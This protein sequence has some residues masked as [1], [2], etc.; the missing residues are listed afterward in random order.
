[1]TAT[2]TAVAGAATGRPRK[3]MRGRLVYRARAMRREPTALVGGG[4]ALLL[5]YLVIAP[6]V[7]ML[8]DA[9]V[10]GAADAS[11]V[12]Q[13]S[14]QLTTYYLSR[15][16]SSPISSLLFWEPLQ[17]T[18]VTALG[19]TLLALSLGASLAWL[20]VRTDMPGRRW[21]AG[22]LVVPYM[23]PSWTFALA[24]I[25]IFKNRT[26]A[27]QSG[28][29]ESMGFAPPDWLAYGAV[30]II[31]TLGLHYFPFAFLLFGNALRRFDAQLE[32][33]ARVLGA[34][35]RQ[36]LWRIVLP[37]ML[38]AIL[39]SV[40][41][42]FSRVL[43]TFGTPYVLGLP[44]RYSVLSTS[45]Y[46]NFRSGSI[47]VMAVIAAVILI[48]GITVIAADAW[49]LRQQRKFITVGARTSIDRASRLRGL[50]PVAL[51]AAI[52][53]FLATVVIPLGAL[54]LSTFMRVPGVLRLDNLTTD[55]WIG[56]I[57]AFVGFP[58]GILR[59]P[60]L[61]AALW[62]SVWIVGAAAIC[63]G[64]LGLLVGY[65]VVRGQGSLVSQFLRQV[66]F[67]PYLVPGIA[68]AAAYLSLF[69]VP[70]GPVPALYG[71]MW[72]LLLVLVVAYLPY[73]SRSGIAA[74]LQLGR[75]P[76]EAAQMSGARW[77]RR[78]SRIVVPIQRAALTT[79]IILPFISGLKELSLVVMLATPGTDVLSTLSVRLV[80][81]GYQQLAN[82]AVL[83]IAVVAFTATFLAQRL[84]G[85]SLASGLG[86]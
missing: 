66:S 55:F 86:R 36:T 34:K 29:L 67:L 33:S 12:G 42:I 20:V 74:M 45:L 71:T 8:S 40:L 41:L 15:T 28:F 27:G 32:E 43:G 3:S 58:V 75:E 76:E 79:G 18:V 73:A 61:Y 70:R 50:R 2:H 85:S 35:S 49:L 83:I 25:T 84:T 26:I 6:I 68:F 31:I 62:N 23:M 53:A 81:Y 63:C 11:R 9:L 16:L 57:P 38:P 1:M 30:P 10:V 24:W 69:A 54:A 5:V 82:A 80:D 44:V 47:G 46:Q 21:F 7:A 19:A 4:L 51:A 64:S 13:P 72:V 65:V 39:S 60:S 22:A 52:A 77:W 48:I 78:I 56:S 59:N 17:H 37:L 14:G